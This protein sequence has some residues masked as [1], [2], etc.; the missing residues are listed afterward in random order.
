MADIG[1]LPAH[2]SPF[3]RR[4]CFSLDG[5]EFVLVGPTGWMSKSLSDLPFAEQMSLH[6]TYSFVLLERAWREL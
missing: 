5:E 3:L 2:I 6:E 1:S 4:F